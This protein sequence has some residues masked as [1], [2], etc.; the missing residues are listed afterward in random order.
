M[1]AT[2]ISPDKAYVNNPEYKSTVGAKRTTFS[3]SNVSFKTSNVSLPSLGRY[4]MAGLVATFGVDYATNWALQKYDDKFK[5]LG[6]GKYAP[7]PNEKKNFDPIVPPSSLPIPPDSLP[8]PDSGSEN[9]GDSK[10]DT[11]LGVLNRSGNNTAIVANVIFESNVKLVNAIDKMTQVIGLHSEAVQNTELAKSATSNERSQNDTA[12]RDATL[13][14]NSALQDYY[15]TSQSYND[16]LLSQN[17]QTLE[18]INGISKSINKID[19]KDMGVTLNRSAN[20]V[21]L[22]SKEL[23]HINFETAEIQL[24]NISDDIPRASPQMMR[25]IKNATVAKKN[26]DENTFEL[27]SGEYDDFFSIPDLSYMFGFD[28]KSERKVKGVNDGFE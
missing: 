13:S 14:Q 18:A 17:S 15:R 25:A 9:G 12:Y 10:A 5:E 16:A 7:K 23:E 21:A 20:E 11:L 4:N 6:I 28:R 8:S 24:D 1:L 26:S 3:P 2:S 19:V 27:D 22:T